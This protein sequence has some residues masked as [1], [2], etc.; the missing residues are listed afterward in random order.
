MKTIGKYQVL[1]LLGRGGMGAVY[2]VRVPVTNRIM[3]LKLLKPNPLLVELLG[4]GAIE[5]QFLAEA[6]ALGGLSHPH[7]AEVWDFGRA[8]GRPFFLMEYFCRDLAQVIGEADR[9]EA[10]T[11]RLPLPRAAAYAVQILSGLARL[12]HAGI[13]HRDVKPGN[14]LLTG[15][16]QVKITDFGLSMVGGRAL[17]RSPSLKVGS[18]YYAAP[19][20]EED[21]DRVG[22]R[23]DLYAV[24]VTLYRMLVGRLPEGPLTGAALPSALSRDL[25]RQWDDFF[26]RALAPDPA[27]RP[28]SAGAMARELTALLAAWRGRLDRACRL[29]E[30]GEGRA[31][32]EGPGQ[33]PGEGPGQGPGEE[34]GQTPGEERGQAPWESPRQGPGHGPEDGPEDGPWDGPGKAPWQ[35]P[36]RGPSNAPPSPPPCPAAAPPR[37]PRAA[38]LKVGVRRAREVFGLDA[39][40]RPVCYPAPLLE[41]RGE[42]VRD[43]ATGLVWQCGGSE[44]ALD[45][46]EA[47]AYVAGLNAQ[48]FAGAAAW[49][50]PTAA[51]LLTVLAPPAQFMG[52]CLDPL[53]DPEKRLLW[54]ADRRTFTKAWFADAEVGA[55]AAADMTCR[56]HVRA[57]HSG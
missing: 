43:G 7:I 36:G 6:A 46:A 29:E 19:E 27:R 9:V 35:G 25:D 13:V 52:H 24:G 22:P 39:L 50:L 30:A 16:D 11:R 49:R 1:G 21:P 44:Y 4:R 5:R 14:L 3:A 28:E 31:P 48:A 37:P 41:P 8:G 55:L 32:W 10:P 47:Q 56:R 18:P 23:A 20:Q 12:H 51:E 45:W 34:P 26:R 54:S 2:K 42:T 40:W 38:P 57:V 17:A 33:G 53:F 15:E